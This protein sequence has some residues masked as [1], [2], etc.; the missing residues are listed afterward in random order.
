MT[1]PLNL[2]QQGFAEYVDSIQPDHNEH[3]AA[4]LVRVRSAIDQHSFWED[5][6][7]W[8]ISTWFHSRIAREDINGK[9]SFKVSVEC[10]GQ[11]FSCLCPSVDKAYLHSKFYRHLIV[12]Q[13][14]S[15]GPPWS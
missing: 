12:S 1:R 13:F 14:Y 3:T 15:V 10:D 11:Q 2:I 7:E 8:R 9:I 4:E 5:Q 6:D